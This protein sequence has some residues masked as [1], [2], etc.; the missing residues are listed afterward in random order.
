MDDPKGKDWTDDAWREPVDIK[1]W[2][3]STNHV[4]KKQVANAER[5]RHPTGEH[6]QEGVYCRDCV[7]F[8]E[9][10][11][12]KLPVFKCLRYG[13]HGKSTDIRKAW[14]GCLLYRPN[15]EKMQSRDNPTEPS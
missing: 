15:L 13:T 8:H 10:K 11:R 5:G 9:E 3:R 6:I 4:P 2:W 12:G 14:V 7:E 1:R